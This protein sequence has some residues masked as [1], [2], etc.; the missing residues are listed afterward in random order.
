MLFG[1]SLA[2]SRDWIDTMK[3]EYLMASTPLNFV[4][5]EGSLAGVGNRRSIRNPFMNPSRLPERSLLRHNFSTTVP[6]STLQVL[7]TNKA[8]SWGRF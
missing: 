1:R 2:I 5:E 3:P 7:W 8:I 4:V 6:K